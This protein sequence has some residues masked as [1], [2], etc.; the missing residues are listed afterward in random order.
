MVMIRYHSF[1][2][3]HT[4][5]A[6]TELLNKQDEAYLAIIKDFNRYDLY[7]KSQKIYDLEDVLAYYQPIA[8]KYLG[9]GPIFW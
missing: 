7:T 2:P 6:Y 5:G 1:Y 9:A 3:W 4:G 8:E